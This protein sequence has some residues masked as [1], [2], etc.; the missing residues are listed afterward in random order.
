MSAFTRDD[1]GR[2]E[3][4]GNA[5]SYLSQ[6]CKDVSALGWCNPELTACS[7]CWRLSLVTLRKVVINYSYVG[8]NRGG[9]CLLCLN[10]SYARA[11][12]LINPRRACAA[13][14]TVVVLSV[15]LSVCRRLFWHYRLWGGL[16]EIPAASELCTRAWKINGWFSWNDC[17]REICR[18]NKRKSQY[19]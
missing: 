12:L 19:A 2:P 4:Y 1:R 18:E 8:K 16:L 6:A 10:A 13:R 5:R 14:V 17:V 3:E 9:N 15:C 11:V 7:R